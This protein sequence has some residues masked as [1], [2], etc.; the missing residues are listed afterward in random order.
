[1]YTNIIKRETISTSIRL[2]ELMKE[3]E[4]T[5][6]KLAQ[7]LNFEEKTV[8]KW[9]KGGTIRKSNLNIL[10]KYFD[11]DVDYLTCKQVKRKLHTI[12]Q[13][14]W[15]REFKED[16][17]AFLE[18]NEYKSNTAFEEL[19]RYADTSCRINTVGHGTTPYESQYISNGE[20]ITIVDFV[21][22]ETKIL[23]EKSNGEKI[24]I[25]TRKYEELKKDIIEYIKF[26][27]TNLENMTDKEIDK[28]IEKDRQEIIEQFD[29]E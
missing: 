6:R 15:E 22:E 12:D 24:Y 10:A 9:R 7:D 29:I 5:C 23:I 27:L 8:Q 21:S 28:D 18:S 17:D 3:K 1:M 16:F 20:L 14:K 19:V 2:S 13:E 11:V 25:S 4:L 26:K